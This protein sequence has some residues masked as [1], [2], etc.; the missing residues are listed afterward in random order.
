MR[1]TVASQAPQP[2]IIVSY[3]SHEHADARERRDEPRHLRVVPRVVP[4]LA[5]TAVPPRVQFP[6]VCHCRLSQGAPAC[7]SVSLRQ[8]HLSRCRPPPP[9]PR[10]AKL[11]CG[12]QKVLRPEGPLSGPGHAYAAEPSEPALTVCRPPAAAIKTALLPRR[13]R[14]MTTGTV[15]S[16]PSPWPSCPPSPL[17]K[18]WVNQA[19]CSHFLV[20]GGRA[21][22][23]AGGRHTSPKSRDARPP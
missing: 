2:Y 22:G 20:R 21:G 12:A 8:R 11:G 9:P 19:C 4:Q 13:S 15:R 18:R 10:H 16:S 17:R 23:L 5:V 6:V 1:H 7:V 14:G 3:R